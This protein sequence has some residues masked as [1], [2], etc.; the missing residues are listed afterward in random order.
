M[1]RISWVEKGWVVQGSAEFCLA[2]ALLA[3]VK[4][5]EL[6][7][8]IFGCVGHDWAQLF[9]ARLGSIGFG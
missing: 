6:R 1:E 3:W 7:W 4:L 2:W 9:S 5:Y 8:N